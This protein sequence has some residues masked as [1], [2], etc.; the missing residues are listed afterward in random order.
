ML[1]SDLL[2]GSLAPLFATFP[3]GDGFYVSLPK[4]VVLLA[5]YFVWMAICRW[6]DEDVQQLRLSRPNWNSYLLAGGVAGLM[7]A[8]MLPW[9]SLALVVALVCGATPALVYVKLRNDE[10]PASQRVLT[11]EH[12]LDLA[13]QYLRLDFRKKAKQDKDD[14][15]PIYFIG[16]GVD[17]KEEDADRVER[18]TSSKGY[19]A[20][21]RLVYEAILSRA[22]D[23]HMEP[24]KED[25]LVRFRIDGIMQ[26]TAPFSRQTG[27]GVINIFKIL[28]NLDIAEKRK[29]QDGS[30]SARAEGRMVDF[31]LATTG[32]TAGEKMV[33]RILDNSAQVIRLDQLGMRQ[34]LRDE[35][36]RVVL[37]P[38]GMFICCGPT[39]AGKTTTL[40]ACLNEIDRFQTNVITIEN[41]VEY[42]L[43]HATQIEINT[44]AGKSFATELRSVLRQDPDVILVGE[45]R[46]QETAEIACQAA[47]TGHMVLTTLHANDTVTALGRLIDLG[48]QPFMLS[49]AISAILGQRLVRILCPECKVKYK[50]TPEELKRVGLKAEQVKSVYRPA[51]PGDQAEG[52]EA[53]ECEHCGG[54]GYFGR[55]GVF[56]LLVVSDTI[57]EMIR[58]NPN[59][60]AIRQEALRGGMKYLQEDGLSL[61]LQ[62]KTSIPELQRVTK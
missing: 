53:V 28:G 3:R 23:I 25:V 19:K 55:T 49:S 56:E 5:L 50:P 18:A 47:Q 37:E 35:I 22:T 39:G 61:V 45:I 29:P 34:E 16:K 27:D 52:E 12:L 30:F 21:R 13:Q 42:K 48:V 54:K 11:P 43:D 10:V 46:D 15:I 59:L 33:L 8:W 2:V 31:R 20:A 62:G 44:K 17:E 26:A 58:E 4:L 1:R 24:T 9:F 41:P 51:G 40:Y 14:N 60:V 6:V 7:L 57:R 38:H 32:S 36:S